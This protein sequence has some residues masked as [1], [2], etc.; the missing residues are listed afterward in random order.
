MEAQL[1]KE[2]IAPT[3][4]SGSAGWHEAIS[5]PNAREGLVLKD[6]H[7]EIGR[8]HVFGHNETEEEWDESLRAVGDG[9]LV[10]GKGFV[11]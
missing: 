9:K 4:V 10:D 8:G 7:G 1:L 11:L 2:S 3:Y 6:A 5:S